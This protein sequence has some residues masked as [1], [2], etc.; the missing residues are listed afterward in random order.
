MTGAQDEWMIGSWCKSFPPSGAG[1]PASQI[2]EAKW[3]LHDDFST[4]V[5]ALRESALA[6]NLARMREYCAENEVRIAPHGKTTMSPELIARQLE[7]GAWAITA[8]TGWQARTMLGFGTRRIIIANECHDPVALRWIAEHVRDHPEVEV[9]VFVDSLVAVELMCAVLRDVASPEPVRPLPVLVEIGVAGGRAGARDVDTAVTLGRAV[10]QAPELELAGVAGF[11]G[12]IGGQRIP[13]I[14]EP[15][16]QF[17]SKIRQ[18]AEELMAISAFRA[19]HPVILSAGGSAFF[20]QVVDVFTTSRDQYPHPVDVVIRSGCYITHDH[21]TY[22]E[23]S[24]F[25]GT[26]E[27]DFQPAI[28]V[29]AR[30]LSMPEPGLAIIDAG[31]RDISI[32][33]RMPLALGRLRDGQLEELAGVTVDRFN[34][35]HGYLHLAEKHGDLLR[36]GDLVRLGIS[37]P[38]TTFDKWRVIPVVDDTYRVISAIRTYF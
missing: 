36:V 31:K 16:R 19:G 5:A 10:A 37:H 28:E 18:T 9:F 30:V 35:Q 17:L 33:S 29:W 27:A 22:R 7:H 24:P 3:R 2:R 25:R 21:A 4:P 20:D 11:E 1:L 38:C 12:V 32:D 6:H 26:G 13:E 8:A 23:S 14:V 34:D 15:V